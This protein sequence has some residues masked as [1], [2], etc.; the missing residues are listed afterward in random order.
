M[1]N[2]EVYKLLAHVRPPVTK[3]PVSSL[4]L[5]LSFSQSPSTK[6]YFYSTQPTAWPASLPLVIFGT[7]PLT[8]L[9]NRSATPDSGPMFLVCPRRLEP[10]THTQFRTDKVVCKEW[11]FF[12]PWANLG[13]T[14]S[15]CTLATSIV[16]VVLSIWGISELYGLL[17]KHADCWVLPSE[18]I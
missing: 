8:L 14:T 4:P 5:T 17:I 10:K 1:N 15:E 13:I 16:V 7:K 3:A 2:W 12:P 9:R 18:R 11:E 6:C